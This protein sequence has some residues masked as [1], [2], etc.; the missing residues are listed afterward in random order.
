ME[1]RW[2]SKW[3]TD[4]KH[5]SDHHTTV[6][7]LHALLS[8]T[9]QL[10][11]TYVSLPQCYGQRQAERRA[12]RACIFVSRCTTRPPSSVYSLIPMLFPTLAYLISRS[13]DDTRISIAA[14]LMNVAMSGFNP[15]Q[16]AIGGVCL[17]L[18]NTRL[19]G[20]FHH[21]SPPPGQLRGRT[22]FH[23]HHHAWLQCKSGSRGFR[24][25]QWCRT[26]SHAALPHRQGSRPPTI[27]HHG[28]TQR[29]QKILR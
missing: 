28:Q 8:I 7:Y 18:R 27:Y 11:K 17:P 25:G 16:E 29:Y 22:L 4:I 13:V 5:S 1:P 6:P 24:P 10:F 26:Q 2:L 12:G 15:S 9:L 19:D 23:K 3:P 20:A 21:Y 14:I